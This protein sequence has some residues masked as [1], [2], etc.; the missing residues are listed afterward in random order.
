MCLLFFRVINSHVS[1][2]ATSSSRIQTHTRKRIH[3][4]IYTHDRLFFLF[5]SCIYLFARFVMNVRTHLK[6][7][8]CIL[9]FE[10]HSISISNS[11]STQ[12]QHH[13]HHHHQHHKHQKIFYVLV[14]V[15]D[16]KKKMKMKKKTNAP[17]WWKP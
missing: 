17:K 11:I 5:F 15:K 10:L 1:M 9:Q 6:G 12:H 7:G 2:K 14:D 8:A 13:H 4:H 3:R 16:K